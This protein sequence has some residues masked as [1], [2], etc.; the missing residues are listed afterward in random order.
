MSSDVL[1]NQPLINQTIEYYQPRC[2]RGLDLQV[3]LDKQKNLTTNVCLCPP[4]SYGSQCQYQNQRISLTLQFYVTSDSLQ[5]PF[6]I[7]VSLIDNTNERIIHS[8]EQ[9]TYLPMKN[10]KRKY[11]IYLLYSTRPKDPSKEYSIHIDIYEKITLNYRA[12]FIKT[13]NFP[14]L[15]VHRLAYILDIPPAMI[16]MIVLD[17]EC[18][19]GKCIKYYNDPTNRT[20]C[21]CK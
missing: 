13:L 17:D 19:N 15:P 6:I 7:I 21:Q 3:W 20:F 9:F 1:K 2:H 14:F 10:C 8:S 16:T 4:S 5:I 11:N 12:S 18:I